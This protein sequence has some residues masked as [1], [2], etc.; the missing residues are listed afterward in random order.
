MKIEELKQGL[1]RI[2]DA[3]NEKLN[4]LCE[5]VGIEPDDPVLTDEED[6]ETE[7]GEGGEGG[8]AS[9]G[10]GNTIPT[11]ENLEGGEGVPQN[12]ADMAAAQAGI[13]GGAAPATEISPEAQQMAGAEGAVAGAEG[14]DAAAAAQ[15]GSAMSPDEE[16]L[17]KQQQ[18]AAAQQ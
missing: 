18:A 11:P 7:D 4:A 2:L 14:A 10:D 3:A 5:Q 13:E 6:T 1:E 8:E 16:E 17:L 15:G 9:A 12:G